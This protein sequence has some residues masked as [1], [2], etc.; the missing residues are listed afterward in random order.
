MF[1]AVH[2]DEQDR[3]GEVFV[4]GGLSKAYEP[5]GK[6]P[7]PSDL[8]AAIGDL[9]AGEEP[10]MSTMDDDDLEDEDVGEPGDGM[11]SG[12]LPPT[13]FGQVLPLLPAEGTRRGIL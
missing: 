9:N 12:K 6:F 4:G 10:E 1:I 13:C 5:I 11:P 3:E 7:V 8:S 2:L